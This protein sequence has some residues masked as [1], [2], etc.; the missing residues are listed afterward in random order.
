MTT[1]S[2]FPVSIGG[3][4]LWR[5]ASPDDKAPAEFLKPRDRRRLSALGRA[6]FTVLKPFMT[7]AEVLDADKDAVL[8]V[9]RFGDL[10]LTAGLLDDMRDRT[11]SR[12]RPS[13]RRSTTRWAGSSRSSRASKAT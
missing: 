13:P 1:T 10:A 4:R 3:V 5:A 6:A 12:P 11:A 7:G 2:A 8:F 9:S